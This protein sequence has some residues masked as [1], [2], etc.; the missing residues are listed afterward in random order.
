MS[1]LR[2][3]IDDPQAGIAVTPPAAARMVFYNDLPDDVAAHWLSILQPQS[4]GPF[5]SKT[6]YAAWRYIPTTYV[7]CEKD[8]AFSPEITEMWI[9]AAKESGTHAID[10]IE[11]VDAG[12][13]PFLSQEDWAVKM[14]RRAAGE[15]ID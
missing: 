4:L 13:F 6:S 14:L 8:Q 3:L 9:K 10:V 7:L 12:H 2:Q 11:R 5:W 15:I 1:F